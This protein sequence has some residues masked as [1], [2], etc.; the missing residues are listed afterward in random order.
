M[1]SHELVD[2]GHLFGGDAL[3]FLD[4]VPPDDRVHAIGISVFDPHLL[5]DESGLR[6]EKPAPDRLLDIE[7]LGSLVLG[8]VE[9]QPLDHHEPELYASLVARDYSLTGPENRRALERGLA[10]AE[11]YRSPVARDE[12]LALM[13][14]RDSPAAW[15][16][17]LWLALTVLAGWWLVATWL[18]WWTLPAALVYGTLYG[19]ASDARWHECGHRTAFRTKWAND[20]V[21]HLASFMDVREPVSWR[22]SHHRHHADTIVVGRDPEIA[23]QRPIRFWKVFADAF[24][25]LSTTAEFRKY[26]TNARGRLTAA[27]AD[28]V[29]PREAGRAV[30]WGRVHVAIWLTT[31]VWSVVTTSIL[32]LMVIGLPSLYGR[33]LLVVFGTTQ[34]AGLAEDVLD[35][36]LNTRTVLMNPILRFLYLNMNYHLE[37]HMF[38]AVPY[39]NLPRLHALIGP[40][41]PPPYRGLL[42]A[43]RD[44]V[45]ALWRQRTDVEHDIRPTVT[46]AR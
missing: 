23:Y 28:Y 7:P 35:H 34:H 1:T 13:Q 41:L 9:G 10:G 31:I 14:R 38:P 16:T 42:H 33:W 6:L 20:V 5:A 15:H 24:G 43:Y 8:D 27:E 19:S 44:I 18:S 30:F 3:P 17:V 25:I 29:P 2:L 26:A 40:D 39:H 11:W 45:P 46:S 4:A 21:Y 36:R 37:H 22:W 32:P 12:L